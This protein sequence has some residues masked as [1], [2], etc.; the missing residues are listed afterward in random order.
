MQTENVPAVSVPGVTTLDIRSTANWEDIASLAKRYWRVALFVFCLTVV[1]AYATISLLTEQYQ[2]ESMLLVKIG[3]ENLDPPATSRNLPLTAGLRHEEVISEIEFLKSAN[4]IQQVVDAVGVEAFRPHRAQPSTLIGKVKETIK[5]LVRSVKSAYQ[6][7]LIALDLKKRLDERQKAVEGVLGNLEVDAVKDADVISVK[8]RMPDPSL[9]QRVENKLIELYMERRIEVRRTPG[10]QEFLDRTSRSRTAEL[11]ALESEKE[12]WKQ[13]TGLISGPEQK[14]LLLKQIRDLSAAHVSTNAE[15]EALDREIAT[16]RQ[17]VSNSPEYQKSTQEDAPNPAMQ[18]VEE[19]LIELQVRRTQSLAK[20]KPDSQVVHDLDQQIEDLQKLLGNQK[21]IETASVTSQLNP[22]RLAVEQKLDQDTIRVEGLR[23][24]SRQQLADLE[25]LQRDLA[26][27][28]VADA[29][30]TAIERNRGIAEQDL[31]TVA[32]RKFDSDIATELD[33][34]QVSNVSILMPP[35]STPEPVYPRK[36]L[37]MA[38]ALAGGLILGIALTVLLN[39]M[40]DSIHD[41][42]IVERELGIPLLGILGAEA[43]G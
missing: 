26:S 13:R 22:N 2:T 28:D 27:L 43:Q 18:S 16:S 37:I 25:T 39:Y 38:V 36:L 3:R 1:T 29:K 23:A 11:T 12:A 20:Y 8:L 14:A 42:A 31:L 32:K 40:D 9:A 15:L 34:E 4:L 33:K 35:S 10:V 30:L 21:S 5:S 19:K 24:M 17:I 7:S 41:P 6:E